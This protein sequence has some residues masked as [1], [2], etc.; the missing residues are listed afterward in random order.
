MNSRLFPS[1]RKSMKVLPILLTLLLFLLV[2][3]QSN[4]QES[5][6]KTVYYLARSHWEPLMLD[7]IAAQAN[8]SLNAYWQDSQRKNIVWATFAI[9]FQRS[10]ICWNFKGSKSLEVGLELAAFT[11]FEFKWVDGI[12][13]RNILNTDFKVGVP[14]VYHSGFWDYRLR[15]FHLSSHWGDDYMIR[16]HI[17]AYIPNAVNYEQMDFTVSYTKD[18]YR[19]YGGA[20]LVVRPHTIRKRWDFEGGFFLTKYLGRQQKRALIG[21]LDVKAYQ[22]NGFNP[23]F[24]MGFGLQLGRTEKRP[25]KIFLQYYH[26]HLPYGVYEIRKVQWLGLGIF[27]NPG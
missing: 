6:G 26:G 2:N 9:G 8:G 27:I 1:T 7:P 14:L 3:F 11:Q 20:G 25:L 19:I 5:P 15:I 21:G 18:F 23:G 12:S 24:N 17:T 4:A 16:N 10:L 13:Q 22:Q